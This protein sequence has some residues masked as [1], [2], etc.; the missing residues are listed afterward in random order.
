[1]AGFDLKLGDR[2]EVFKDDK[3]AASMIE[4]ITPGGR[5]VISEPMYG[6]GR[7]PVKNN[8]LLTISVFRETGLLSFTATAEKI[9]YDNNLTFIEIEIRSKVT[10]NQRRDYVRFETMLKM[11]VKPLYRSGSDMIGDK[12]AVGLLATR[13]ISG[14]VIDADGILSCMTLDISGGGARFFGRKE[15]PRGTVADC[16]IILSDGGKIDACIRIIRNEQERHNGSV[17][18]GARFIG[19][20]EVLRER[21]IKYIFAEQL[22]QRKK[23][24]R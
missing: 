7:L 12:E 3:R 14:E 21:I 8:D 2:L 15:L 22:R 11:I 18:M 10:R 5:L 16:E 17:I 13:R 4:T 23:A 20:Q 1:M 19:I 24:N 9:Y 6:L